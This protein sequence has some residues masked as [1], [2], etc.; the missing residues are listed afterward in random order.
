MTEENAS[1]LDTAQRQWHGPRKPGERQRIRLTL[2]SRMPLTICVPIQ[3]MQ[4][5]DLDYIWP[6]A[7]EARNNSVLKKLEV[8]FSLSLLQV[9]R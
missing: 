8:S 7:T 9:R 3:G 5:T 4:C 1:Q 2:E 6:H